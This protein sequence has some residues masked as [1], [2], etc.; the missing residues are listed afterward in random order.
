[1]TPRLSAPIQRPSRRPQLTPGAFDKP[2]LRLG[3]GVEAAEL[4]TSLL[5]AIG[6]LLGHSKAS[7]THR[8]AHLD[9]DPMRRAVET[10]GA[11]ITAAMNGANANL[12]R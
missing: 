3:G 9:A 6:K 10:I 5:A 1:M 8:S 7:T 12:R 11:T 2:S 4:P